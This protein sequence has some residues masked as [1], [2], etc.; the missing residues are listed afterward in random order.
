[1][2][3]RS[4]ASPAQRESFLQRTSRRVNVFCEA[5]L[6]ASMVL[7]ATITL[8]QI[9]FRLWFRALTW[10]EELTCFLL[11]AASFLGSAVAFKRGAHIAVTILLN[12]L[13][14]ALKRLTLLFIDGVGVA[15]FAVL[16]Y[17]GAVLCHQEAGQTATAIALSMSW[18]YLIFPITGTIS[19][20]HLLAHGEKVLRGEV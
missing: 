1:M 7:M 16:T 4:S 12:L 18:I 20:L 9:V 5:G 19:I 2:D 8:L 3:T 13:P 14:P 17:Y 6:F 11:V 10:S 15:F